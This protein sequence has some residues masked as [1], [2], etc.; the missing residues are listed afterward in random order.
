M[1]RRHAAVRSRLAGETERRDP[2]AA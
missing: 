1:A 2:K